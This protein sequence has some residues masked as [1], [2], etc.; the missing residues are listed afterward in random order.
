METMLR[1]M[2]DCPLAMVVGVSTV[3][4]RHM[5]TFFKSDLH[6]WIDLNKLLVVVFEE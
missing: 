1:V 4:A 6:Q 5:E 3:R 2:H